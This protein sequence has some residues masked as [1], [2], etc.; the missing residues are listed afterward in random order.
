ME[1]YL[2]RNIRALVTLLTISDHLISFFLLLHKKVMLKTLKNGPFIIWKKKKW[3][4]VMQI[5]K[6]AHAQISAMNLLDR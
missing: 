6:K 4:P 1:V 5:I 2:W 3:D